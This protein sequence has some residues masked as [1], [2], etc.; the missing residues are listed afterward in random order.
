M[1]R[2]P[3]LDFSNPRLCGAMSLRNGEYEGHR[4]AAAGTNVEV[5]GAQLA[6]RCPVVPGD[7]YG[8]VGRHLSKRLDQAADGERTALMLSGVRSK[9]ARPAQEFAT[10]SYVIRLRRA[11]QPCNVRSSARA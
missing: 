8:T 2:F 3:D 6:S 7:L 9:R 1:R 10:H 11:C 5:H 4:L